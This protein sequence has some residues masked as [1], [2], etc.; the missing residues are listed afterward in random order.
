[1]DVF[2]RVRVDLVDRGACVTTPYGPR[3]V[4]YADHV[5][6]GRHLR[7]VE[8]ALADAVL[9]LYANTHTEDS[10]LGAHTTRLT[11]EAAE[12]VKRCLG[13]GPDYKLLF[14]GTGATGA[15]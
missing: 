11:H 1:M 12:Y 5:A 9:P 4:T 7:S 3:R 15:L 14:P 8:R 10:A 13:A 6:S 2:E